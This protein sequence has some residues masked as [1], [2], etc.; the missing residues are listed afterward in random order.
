MSYASLAV[1]RLDQHDV[2]ALICL[3]ERDAPNNLFLLANLAQ[4][5]IACPFLRYFGAFREGELVAVL[6]F[7]RHSAG[8]YWE[9]AGAL[10]L[11]G[12]LF[13]QTS[14]TALS[15]C[16][17]QVEPWLPF[18]PAA[19]PERTLHGVFAVLNPGHLR[20]WAPR[21][22]RLAT[23][24]DA[25]LLAELYGRNLLFTRQAREEHRRRVL[26]TLEAGGKIALVERDGRAVSAARTSAVGHGMAMIGGVITLP[27][28]RR[29]GYATACTGLLSQELISSGI[30]PYLVYNP[31]DPA[32]ARVYQRLGFM[33]HDEWLVLFWDV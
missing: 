23:P 10:P 14:V 3:L 33:P 17:R 19:V 5:G 29:Q 8:L 2:P 18:L 31:Q 21:G 16:R 6:M 15:G 32:A 28:Y 20:P 26:E 12:A 30:T 7:F 27:N 1:R 13:Q 22:E 25:D 9:D 11:F 4:W 24:A